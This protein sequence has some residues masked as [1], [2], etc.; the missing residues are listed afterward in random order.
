M[1]PLLLVLAAVCVLP[2]ALASQ[3][4]QP[5]PRGYFYAYDH[6]AKVFYYTDVQ[7]IDTRAGER[8]RYDRRNYEAGFAALK[9]W[10]QR[11]RSEWGTGLEFIHPDARMGAIDLRVREKTIARHAERGYRLERIA[12]PKP[13]PLKFRA[14]RGSRQ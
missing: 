8:S 5:L 13:M 1:R 3:A 4:A 2:T 14:G 6:V 12:V 11:N 10:E 9:R 7:P